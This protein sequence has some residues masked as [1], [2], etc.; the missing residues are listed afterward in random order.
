MPH[1]FE[2]LYCWVLEL[3]LVNQLSILGFYGMT[4]FIFGVSNGA[5]M[6]FTITRK[7]AQKLTFSPN[8][9]W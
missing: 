9:R 8:L 1:K 3:N 7:I 6:L 5:D 4:F 2:T